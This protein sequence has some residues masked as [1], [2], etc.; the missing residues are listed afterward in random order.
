MSQRG[1]HSSDARL[2]KLALLQNSSLSNLK[3]G[4]NN[5]GDEGV[6]TLA[7]GIA[8]HV[9]ISALDLGFNNVGDIGCMALAEAIL[10]RNRIRT[11]CMNSATKNSGSNKK[12]ALFDTLYLAGNCIGEEGATSLA[13]VVRNGCGL[14]RLHLTGNGVGPDGIRVLME[15]ITEDDLRQQREVA[16]FIHARKPMSLSSLQS[17]KGAIHEL[18]LGGTGMGNVGC[19]AVGKMLEQNSSLRV[20]SLDN[21]HMGDDEGI[22]L[23]DAIKKNQKQLPL[24][25]IKL[26]FNELTCKSIGPLM[27]AFWASSSL[28]ELLLDNNAIGDEGIEVISNLLSAAPT[29]KKLDVGFNS[30]SIGGMSKLMK[31]I[32]ENTNLSSLSISGNLVDCDSAKAVAYALAYNKSLESFFMDHCS[33]ESEG[34]RHICAGIVS[35]SETCLHTV[36]G[37]AIGGKYIKF[38]GFTL[39]V[40]ELF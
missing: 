40:L 14:R 27:N 21:C 11:D 6:S 33:I 35:N 30:M 4:Y 19:C 23:A 34:Q 10:S 24:E 15:A 28:K 8:I 29:L 26:S 31:A 1:L 25:K 2:V 18:F 38:F 12:V 13:S 36:T 37:I 5:L 22:I 16:N 7:S 9:A 17:P 32:A 39:M 20:L 3:L